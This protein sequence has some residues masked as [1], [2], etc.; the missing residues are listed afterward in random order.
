MKK[1]ALLMLFVAP[2][3]LADLSAGECQL[4]VVMKTAAGESPPIS[5]TRCL[6]QGEAEKLFGSNVSGC[7][8]SN[9]RDDGSTFSFDVAC[10][11]QVQVN[12]SGSV[13]YTSQTLDGELAL[14][15]E[16]GGQAIAT[17]SRVSGRRTGP[18]KA[19]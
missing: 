7:T 15:A 3:A 16:M 14:R 12:G 5:D 9:K 10:S 11:G 19:P 4:T 6:R 1:L 13:S 18:C 8:F 2:P 17:S